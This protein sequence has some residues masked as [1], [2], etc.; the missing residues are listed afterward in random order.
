[1]K[2]SF[3]VVMLLL[4][5]AAASAISQGPGGRLYMTER[6]E[7]EFGD[8]YI[9]LKSYQLDADWVIVGGEAPTDHG[10]ILDNSN[11]ST[12][13][14]SRSKAGSGISPE[15]VVGAGEGFGAT[16]VMGANYNNT[17]LP[18]L[19]N[20]EVMDILK[21]TTTSSTIVP[22]DIEILGDGRAAI[23]KYD[24][25]WLTSGHTDRGAIA[26]P[27][28][29]GGF[30]GEGEYFVRAYYAVD[31]RMIVTDTNSD[32][33]CTDDDEDY[34]ALNRQYQ[35]AGWT[36]HEFLGDKLFLASDYTQRAEVDGLWDKFPDYD[37]RGDS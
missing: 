12:G 21:I 36:D 24:P 6:V 15:I 5:A 34:I 29:A 7:D 4:V 13:S 33:D 22:A 14:G 9:S 23:L 37:L 32:G 3:A 27:D 10:L 25:D 19:P 31:R 8:Y 28:P 26:A 11:G 20:Y 17:P 35:A 16:I 30:M 2:K 1:M 18:V